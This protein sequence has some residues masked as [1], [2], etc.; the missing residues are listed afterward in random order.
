M[1]QFRKLK[2][3]Q[4]EMKRRFETE[5]KQLNDRHEADVEELLDDF[6]QRLQDVQGMYEDSKKKS[7][8]LKM[9]NEEKLTSQE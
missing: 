9:K 7:D 5:I 3:F 2:E 8:D 6:K 4:N 1:D